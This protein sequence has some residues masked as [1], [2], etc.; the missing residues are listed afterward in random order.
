[1][2][3]A[4]EESCASGGGIKVKVDDDEKAA[5]LRDELLFKQTESSHYGDCPICCLPLSLVPQKSLM[6]PCCSKFI[7]RGCKY[8]NRM[9]E[10]EGRLQ[11]QCPFCRHPTVKSMEEAEINH[12]KR[13]KANDPVA[14]SAM[15]GHYYGNKQQYKKAFEYY[16][17]AAALGNMD[18]H[19]SLAFLYARGD[20]VEK[21]EKKRVYH[22]EEAAI[23]GHADARYYLGN[24]EVENERY[25]RAIKHWIIAA[26]MGH[27]KSLGM[28]KENYANGYVAKDDFA[29]ALRAH[30][31]AV[32]AT[33]SPERELA[34]VVK[35]K[36]ETAKVTRQK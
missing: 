28:L 25:D 2:S 4:E 12:M 7:C 32:V 27:D 17:K 23:G 19:Y 9:R 33:K 26:N 18:A 1:M 31:A 16:T 11:H 36:A 3:G 30:H 10:K 6:Y 20:G 29:S 34:E 22:F 35:Q 8:A 21:D 13:V 14:L 24:F 5:E 15:G